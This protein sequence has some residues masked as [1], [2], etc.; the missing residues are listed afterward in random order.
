MGTRDF[1][2][3][4]KRPGREADHS[5]PSSAEVKNAWSYT[6]TPQYVF[7]ACC[8][9]EY[10]DNFT[11]IDY[12]DFITYV[13]MLS[14]LYDYIC[15]EVFLCFC[16]KHIFIF[17]SFVRLSFSFALKQYTVNIRL[18]SD[19]VSKNVPEIV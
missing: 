9:L 10:R 5:R 17:F 15:S 4:V 8:L 19:L 13:I 2:L 6:S 3:G 7:M 16:L 14:V 1:S 18:N 12:V 11:C